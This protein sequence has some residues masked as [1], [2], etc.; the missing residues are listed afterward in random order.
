[1]ALV[2]VSSTSVRSRSRSPWTGEAPLVD[3]SS[4]AIGGNVSAKEF[5]DLPSFNRNFTG[6]L[7]ARAR[8]GRSGL[9]HDVRGRL[10]QRRR[11]ERAQRELHD[12]RVEQQRRV[13]RRQWRLPGPYP[14]R[15][16]AGVPVAHEPVRRRV[17]QRLGRRG[18]LRVQAGHQRLPRQRV[19]VLPGREPRHTRLLRRRRRPRETRRP[20]SSSS[21]ARLVAPSSRTRCISSAA[22]SASS[23]TAA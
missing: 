9:R 20:S 12:G 2:E 21:A 8:C 18:Q 4:K 23:S 3:T 1:M 19:H 6:Y 16:R 13:Q 10:H 15:G 5:V 14:R 7:G 22:S 17:R 11:P